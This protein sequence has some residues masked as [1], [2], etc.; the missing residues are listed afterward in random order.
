MM[1]AGDMMIEVA[2]IFSRWTRRT[3]R[4]PMFLFFALLQP[5]LFFVLFTQSF[6]RIASIPGFSQTTG[7]DSYLT[8]YSAAVVLQTVLTSAMQAGMGFVQDLE[9]GFMDKLKAAP[10]RRSSIL[11]GKVLSDGLRVILQ[12]S[13]IL[14]ICAALGVVFVTGVP[15]VLLILLMALAF[16]V[17]WSGISTFVALATKN[18]EATFMVAMITTFPL[19]FLSTA[20]MPKPF[21]PAWVQ[22]FAAYNPIS[23]IG[24]AYHSIVITGYDWA[25]IGAAFGM[26]VLVGA[27]TLTATTAMFKRAVRA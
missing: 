1:A 6:S 23:Y 22:S 13:I 7:T 18:T 24:D 17:A 4:Q 8:Y 27:I 5:V 9:S 12:T 20:V 14:L 10:I 25:A 16:G 3:L 21:L 2:G 19:L 11:L 26:C 15:G